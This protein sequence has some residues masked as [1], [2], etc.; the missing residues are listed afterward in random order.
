MG[1]LPSTGAS[2]AFGRVRSRGGWA[3]VLRPTPES[4]YGNPSACASFPLVPWSNRIKDAAFRFRGQEYALRPT[5]K[6]GAALHGVGRNF[7]WT[8]KFADSAH[9]VLRFDATEPWAQDTPINFPWP[10][11][12]Q[13]IY[14]L[15]GE[16]FSIDMAMRNAGD[17][18]F[19]AG[20]GHHP[21]FVRALAGQEDTANLEI[22]CERHF[23][24]KNAI[25]IGPP[26]PIPAHLDFRRLRAL[27]DVAID[28]NL[29]GRI[30][31]RPVLIVYP[32]SDVA[33]CMRM[34]PIFENIILFTPMEKPFFAVEPVTN[35]NDGFN[36]YADGVPGSGVFVLDPG[37]S[38]RGA[39]TLD[40]VRL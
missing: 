8:V 7:P 4:A 19:P 27:D 1:I 10:F 20:F 16:R 28:D 5:S 6:D 11:C 36:L 21:Y 40:V 17:T 18:P 37:Q 9:I 31:G 34:A 13:I 14:R 25:P 26:Q 12:A 38:V 15:D 35:A 32:R 29:T 24:A 39:I 22:P 33:L 30:P 2:I 3:D 23:P